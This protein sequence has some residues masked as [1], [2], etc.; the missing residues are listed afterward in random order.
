MGNMV[1]VY[2][3]AELEGLSPQEIEQLKQQ[4]LHQLQ[5]SPE[6]RARMRSRDS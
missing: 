2:T 5:N 4:I 6:I 1:G 3:D